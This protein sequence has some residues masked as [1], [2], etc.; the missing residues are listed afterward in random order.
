MFSFFHCEKY[1]VSPLLLFRQVKA[2]KTTGLGPNLPYPVLNLKKTHMLSQIFLLLSS[3]LP[4]LIRVAMGMPL[5]GN[6]SHCIFS[7]GRFTK[8]NFKWWSN[9]V[10]MLYNYMGI[11][12]NRH[13]RHEQPQVDICRIFSFFSTVSFYFCFLLR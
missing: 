9:T 11:K 3:S 8:L 2:S 1:Q 5:L 13:L 6:F 4:Y 10:H 7:T 12:R